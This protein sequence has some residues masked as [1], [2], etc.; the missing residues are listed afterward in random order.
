MEEK[1]DLR[2]EKG[3]IILA[4][5]NILVSLYM[6]AVGVSGLTSAGVDNVAHF[7]G[8]ATGFIIGLILY[9]RR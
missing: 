5:A 1:Q 3:C 7:G 6:F 4:V 9:K 2:I 8:L